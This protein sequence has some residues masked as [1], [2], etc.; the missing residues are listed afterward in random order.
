V[1]KKLLV[2]LI[3]LNSFSYGEDIFDTID[4]KDK[5]EVKQIEQSIIKEKF[6]EAQ[7]ELEEQK[8]KR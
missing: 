1:I 8:Q 3:V 5:A 6:D 4:S 2:L 7:K